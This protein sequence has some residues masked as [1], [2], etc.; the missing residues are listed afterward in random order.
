LAGRW[1]FG[2]SSPPHAARTA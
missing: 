1:H 2:R